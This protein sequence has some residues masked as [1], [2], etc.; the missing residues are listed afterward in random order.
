[1]T[2]KMSYGDFTQLVRE[3]KRLV[4]VGK[5]SIPLANDTM[6]RVAVNNG[7]IPIYLW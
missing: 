6:Q 1:M 2:S 4:D 3:F 7:F 5:I